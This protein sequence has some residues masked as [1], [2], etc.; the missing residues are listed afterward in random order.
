MKNLIKNSVTVALLFGAALA[1]ITASTP[2]TDANQVSKSEGKYSASM[3]VGFF[4]P[5]VGAGTEPNSSASFAPED[6]SNAPIYEHC[7]SCL[8]GV[9]S[10][11]KDEIVRCTFCGVLKPSSNE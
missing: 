8:T 5:V 10:E 9:Y 2:K 6:D 4:C 1:M 7:R 11:H 3:S